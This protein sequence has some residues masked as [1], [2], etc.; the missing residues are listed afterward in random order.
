MTSYPIFSAPSSPYSGFTDMTAIKVAG[1]CVAAALMCVTIKTTRPEIALVLSIAAG[2]VAILWSLDYVRATVDELAIL[3]SGAGL[4]SGAFSVMLRAVGIAV[5]T[6]FASGV[7]R[8]A[9]ESALCARIEF[10]GRAA[11]LAMCAPILTGIINR[12]S[13]LLT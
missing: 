11:L 2:T 1:L 12:L 13:G 5:I 9:G 4:E 7:C 8:D 6:E 3:A 10:C